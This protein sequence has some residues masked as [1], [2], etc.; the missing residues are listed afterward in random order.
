[1]IKIIAVGKLNQKG[2]LDQLSYYTKQLTIKL[3]MIEV[4]D[5]P[6]IQG[7]EVEGERI[8]SK[9][10][11]SDFVIALA[12]DGKMMSSEEFASLMD[13][14]MTYSS[15]DLV[16]IIGGSYGLSMGVMHRANMKLSFSKM[17]FP[18]QLMRLI[19]VEQIYRGQM[20][21]KHHPYHK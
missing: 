5:E 9:V 8:L 6:T 19:L 21:L 1:M 16:F 11:P 18:H 14:K 7:M 2:I 12:I 15:S 20:I 10:N 13:E 4:S 3:D 17:T